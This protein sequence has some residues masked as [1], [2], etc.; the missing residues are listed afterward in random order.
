MLKEY[1]MLI[2]KLVFV[3]DGLVL[4]C[5]FLLT[6]FLRY[7]MSLLYPAKFALLHE[8]PPIEKYAWVI[9]IFVPLWIVTLSYFGTY[10]S[11]RERR[12]LDMFWNIV[13]ACILSILIFSAATFLFKLSILS[14][15]FVVLLFICSLLMLIMEKWFVLAF[16]HYMRRGGYNFR[17]LLVVGSGERAKNFANLITSHPHWGLKIFGFIDEEEKVGIPVGKGKV[18]GSFK[19]LA[20]ILDQNV[21]NEVVFILPRKWLPKLEDYI[22]ICEKVGVKATIAVDFFNTMIAKPTVTEL[23]G[24]PLLTLDS[25]PYDE[26]QLFVKRL[27]DIFVSLFALIGTLPVFIIAAIAIKLSAPGPV[28]FKQKRCGLYGR[29]FTLYKFRTMITGADKM[30]EKVMHLNESKGPVFH[31]RNDPRVTRIGR[32]LRKTSIDELPQL[33]N[34]LIGDMSVIGPR[35]PIPEEVQLYER[36]QRR[37]LSFRPGIVCTWQVSKRFQSDFKQWMQMDLDYID[38]WSLVCDIKILIRILPALVKGFVHWQ[39]KSDTI[40]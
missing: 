22:K 15:S 11:M 1:D 23:E 39:T 38:N 20:N 5:A 18:I 30:L 4:G 31:S 36:W 26:F 37:R 14:R 2:R 3:A 32:I 29:I 12:F 8:L 10:H 40:L 19:D 35:P 34:V 7:K 21:V 6:Y 17:V 27:M 33:I 9:I 28:F 13:C 16:L 24:V 25:T